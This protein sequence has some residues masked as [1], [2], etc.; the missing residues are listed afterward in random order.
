MQ[1]IDQ[2]RDRIPE[3]AK[4]LSLNLSTV[5]SARGSPAL[6]ARQI[7]GTA[8]ACA[9][10]AGHESLTA[11]IEEAGAAH[12]TEADVR[13]ARAAAAIMGMNNVYYRFVHFAGQQEYGALPAR[14]RMNVIANPGVAKADFE[15][16]SL[17]VSAI[18]GCELCVK[19]HEATLRKH[20]VPKEA[21]QSAARIAAV[22]NAV[23]AVLQDV[24]EPAAR[25]A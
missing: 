20:E 19:S 23:G 6:E 1:S 16:Y 21:I 5:L 13:A 2:I 18:N 14:L 8:L 22:V 9:V 24:P 17:A 4:D 10:A 7:F 25:A 11:A 15:L 12:L 3:F